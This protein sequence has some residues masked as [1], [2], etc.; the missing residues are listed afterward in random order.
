MAPDCVVAGEVLSGA[1]ERE[2]TLNARYAISCAHKMGCRVFLTWEDIVQVKPK[3]VLTLLAA[4]MQQDMLRRDLGRSEVL[5]ELQ[6][7]KETEQAVARESGTTSPL[8]VDADAGRARPGPPLGARMQPAG[9]G[10][11]GFLGALR[12]SVA[13][14]GSNS[15]APKAG[16]QGAPQAKKYAGE[17]E[18]SSNL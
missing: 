18:Y 10:G 4:A 11:G 1:T 3:M 2:C 6:H 13:G 16:K 17:G 7:F 8:M 15:N 12:S 5:N 14:L 9:G